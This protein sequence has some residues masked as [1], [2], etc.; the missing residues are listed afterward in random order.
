[1]LKLI[2]K[3][4]KLNFSNKESLLLTLLFIPFIMLLLDFSVN[5]QAIAV[6]IFATNYVLTITPFGYEEK[7]KPLI[8]IQSLPITKKETVI[9]K[10]IIIFINY[11]LV[12]VYT[13]IYL[14]IISFFGNR[15]LDSFNISIIRLTLPIVILFVSTILPAY[16]RLVPRFANAVGVGVFI[17]TSNTF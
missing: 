17:F 4:L 14:W 12:I 15:N 10:Y 3:D 1:M 6:M 8:L 9:S 5:E 13:Y 2:R 7:S 16:F 11:I